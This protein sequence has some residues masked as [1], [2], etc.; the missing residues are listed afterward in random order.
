[1]GNCTPYPELTMSMACLFIL[2]YYV[3]PEGE[4]TTIMNWDYK[5][6]QEF[7]LKSDKN[8]EF[9]VENSRHLP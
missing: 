3:K 5:N 8:R 2:R 7:T 6:Q 1:M 4:N 9:L